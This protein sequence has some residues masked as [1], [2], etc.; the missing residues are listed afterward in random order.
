MPEPRTIHLLTRDAARLLDERATSEFGIPSIVLME[1]AARNIGEVALDALDDIEQPRVLVLAGPGNN[2]GDGTALARHLHNAGVQTL[3]RLVC[4]SPRPSSDAGVNLAIARAMG[5]V[6][7]AA[8]TLTPEGLEHRS[9]AFAPD[10][11][12][13]AIFGTGLERPLSS[14][15][16]R[17]IESVNEHHDAGVRILSV[18]LPSGLDAQTGRPKPV[19]IRADLTV[20]LAGLKP[21]LLALEAQPYVG[22]LMVADIGVPR[23]LV[24]RLGTPLLPSPSDEPRPRAKR[25]TTRSRR[26]GRRD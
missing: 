19:A 22:D 3:V 24:E 10:L 16:G 2:G 23:D 13:D 26:G 4:G 6:D 15:V 7:D 21:G 5:L 8:D 17:L 20:T 25:R 12:I 9:D 11:I 1:N 18:D 14:E